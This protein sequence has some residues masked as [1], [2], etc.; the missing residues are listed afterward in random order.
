M[1]EP[2]DSPQHQSFHSIEWWAIRQQKTVA[3]KFPSLV[4]LPRIPL[5]QRSPAPGTSVL[6]PGDSV[7]PLPWIPALCSPSAL[8]TLAAPLFMF[9][10]W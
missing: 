7:P 8:G 2:C 6:C 4:L 1:R 3:Q 10:G 9:Y 5:S